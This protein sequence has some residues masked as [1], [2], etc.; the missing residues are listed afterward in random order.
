MYVWMGCKSGWAIKYDYY[1]YWRNFS[2]TQFYFMA[3]GRSE[4]CKSINLVGKVLKADEYGI[5]HKC[6]LSKI[7]IFKPLLL[8]L[9]QN[10]NA[11]KNLFAWD[12][13][14]AWDAGAE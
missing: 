12:C 11:K 7:W 6:G 14:T 2:I 8:F 4:I 5:V 1:F 3:H 13:L 9:S 10:L